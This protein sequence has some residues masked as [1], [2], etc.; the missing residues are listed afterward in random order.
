VLL[1][2]LILSASVLRA[3]ADPVNVP[4]PNFRACLTD[5]GWDPDDPDFS[6]YAGVIGT[7][8]LSCV[9]YGISDL[10]GLEAFTS[11]HTLY[12]FGN[13]ITD[14]SPL[15]GLTNL[16]Y[17]YLQDNLITDVS[18]L[19][20]LVNPIYLI[21]H[22]NLITDISPLANFTK[23]GT[24]LVDVDNNRVG[25]LSAFASAGSP[26]TTTMISADGQVVD[27]GDVLM[28]TPTLTPIKR[29]D[30]TS[31]DLTTTSSSVSIDNTAHTFTLSATGP[32]DLSWDDGV[33]S[34]GSVIECRFSGT[35][36]VN[37]V[38]PQPLI[39]PPGGG[40]GGG[41]QPS[42]PP[43]AAL[44]A[45]GPSGISSLAAAAL[46]CVATGVLLRRRTRTA[47]HH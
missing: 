39:N 13:Q 31:S 32:N 28:G 14:I 26:V 4:D 23:H 37:G 38:T 3:E 21:L 43:N 36:I 16:R 42:S 35:L 7:D 5:G 30:G 22:N 33:F 2:W 15:A 41:T 46:L 47:T 8:A 12:L 9:N 10:T 18:P 44:P 17:V 27:G 20:N 11:L 40:G 19:A 45:T 29:P 25:D 1:G 24:V 34:I 6:F